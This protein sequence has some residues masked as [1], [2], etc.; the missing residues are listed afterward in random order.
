MYSQF[1]G[2]Q[3]LAE[4]AGAPKPITQTCHSVPGQSDQTE[5]PA[6]PADICCNIGEFT[7]VDSQTG[8][9][10]KAPAVSAVLAFSLI[11]LSSVA[12]GLRSDVHTEWLACS[13]TSPPH[14][15]HIPTT[16]LRI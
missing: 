7:S 5:S 12:S 11:D 2:N 16:I 3:N 10:I 14:F 8:P 9:A 6:K 13:P 15:T 1:L 4:S